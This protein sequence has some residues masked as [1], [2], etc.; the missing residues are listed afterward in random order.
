MDSNQKLLEE[1]V[2]CI[3]LGN[4][5]EALSCFTK[6]LEVDLINIDALLKSG[7]VLGKLG[8]YQKAIDM[9]KLF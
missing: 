7:H 6:V 8:K 5:K 1:G 9:Y 3:N 2:K 4:P